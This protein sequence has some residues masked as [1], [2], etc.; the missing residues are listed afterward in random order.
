MET[1]QEVEQMPDTTETSETPVALRIERT[2]TDTPASV[3]ASSKHRYRPKL[4]NVV[5]SAPA[6]H[7]TTLP[8]QVEQPMSG[9]QNLALNVVAIVVGLILALILAVLISAAVS[10]QIDGAALFNAFSVRFLSL[11]IEAAPF[12]LLG[13]LVSGLIDSFVSQE[14][15]VRFIPR[16]R[17]L[18]VLIGTF[19]GF[20]FPVCE[21]GVVPVVRQL[22]N[23][24]LPAAVGVAFLLAAPVMNP[25]V[26]LST[27]AA[28][29]FGPVVVGRYVIT[30]LVAIAVGM[31]FAFGKSKL[32]I[33]GSIEQPVVSHINSPKM[34]TNLPLDIADHV[35][36]HHSSTP[37]PISAKLRSTFNVAVDEF[38]EMGRFLII[39]CILAAAMQTLVSQDVLA[40]LG[41]GPITSVLTMQA[42]AFLLSVCS[43]VDAFIALAFT[44]VFTT[45]SIL[46]FLTFGPMVDIKTTV[47]FMGIFKRRTVALLIALPLIL[48][49]IS[50]IL[51]NLIGLK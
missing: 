17:F 20:V 9:R 28:F 45:A 32:E 27:I 3:R 35:S 8:N 37:I 44:G 21:C 5:P 30:A 43:T 29:G 46:A 42:L 10:N 40:G 19:I 50:G 25:I 11:F 49:A 23:K 39:G 51:L 16:N 41:Q 26:L 38:F 33:R 47:M 7:T 31:I 4:T 6:D 15:I 22:F 1:K 2:Q 34:E 24:K 14:H 36:I 18:G 13:T 12:L 48:T